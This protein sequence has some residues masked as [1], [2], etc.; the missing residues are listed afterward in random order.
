MAKI[1]TYAK[2]KVADTT[3]PKEYSTK[4]NLALLAQVARVLEDSKHPGISRTKTRSEVNRSRR[5]IYRQKGTGG[6]RHGSK[7]APIFVGGGIAHGPKGI[8]RNLSISKKKT[9]LALKHAISWKAGRNQVFAFNGGQ[10]VAKT[11]EVQE[12][13]DKVVADLD[14]KARMLFLFAEKN[15]DFAKFYKNIA[16]V[17]YKPFAKTNA[18]DVVRAGVVMLDKDIFAK[19][20]VKKAKK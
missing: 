13:V 16:N 12:L 20:T 14:K 4:P 2:T 1:K 3:L 8:K 7:G 19:K 15:L 9:R 18:N 11:K 5:K 6:A 10:K 17:S